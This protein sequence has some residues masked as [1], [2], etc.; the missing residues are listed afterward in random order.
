MPLARGVHR[1]GEGSGRGRQA[2]W[3]AAA[4]RQAALHG[5]GMEK[6]GG[7][8]RGSKTPIERGDGIATQI[9]LSAD[10]SLA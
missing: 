1:Q 8:K 3:R 2:G 6:G 10:Y 4:G 9:P 5:G 7:G